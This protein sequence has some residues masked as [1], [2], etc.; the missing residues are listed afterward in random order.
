MSKIR[1]SSKNI[2]RLQE[3]EACI[4]FDDEKRENEGDFIFA[5]EFITPEKIN[6]LTKKARGT[7]CVALSQ[8][9]AD[10]NGLKLVNQDK[11]LSIPNFTHPI[12]HRDTTTGI[13]VAERAFTINK[14]LDQN[15]DEA[16]FRSPG[17]INCLIEHPGGFQ[18]R[19]GHT[20]GS[21]RL[22]ELAYLQSAAV[23]CEILND[24]G[25]MARRKDLFQL[26]QQ[27]EIPYITFK[28]FQ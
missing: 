23:I 18:Q 27:L 10:K 11:D 24:D 4:L 25:T 5:A 28:D 12:D 9:I 17:H 20:E 6:F 21:L 26:S 3:G 1:L 22:M 13:S 8:S 16:S 2:R 14:L 15:C 19:Q 7:I